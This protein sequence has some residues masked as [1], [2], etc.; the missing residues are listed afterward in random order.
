VSD[1]DVGGVN[2]QNVLFDLKVV[3]AAD[4]IL[5]VTLESSYGLGGTFRCTS[6]EST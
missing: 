5:E 6:V 2:Q 4:E 1:L 3:E